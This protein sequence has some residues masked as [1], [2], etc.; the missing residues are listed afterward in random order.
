MGVGGVVVEGGLLAFK[1]T[2]VC[3]TESPSSSVVEGEGVHQSAV[4][5]TVNLPSC[6][7]VWVHAGHAAAWQ[8]A[9]DFSFKEERRSHSIVFFF[10]I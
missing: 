9:P 3:L 5:L 7:F 8:R 6:A 2:H 10:K 4:A 1:R